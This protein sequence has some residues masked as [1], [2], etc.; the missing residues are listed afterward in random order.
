LKKNEENK[1]RKKYIINSN[2]KFYSKN[3]EKIRSSKNVWTPE[4]Q[5][6][7][8]KL[9]SIHGNKWSLISKFIPQK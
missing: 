3:F 7:F 9:H 8:K 2:N 4:E 5:N 1:E 6:L